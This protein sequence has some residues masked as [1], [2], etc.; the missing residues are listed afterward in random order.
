MGITYEM[1][2]DRVHPISEREELP[3]D[4]LDRVI[5]GF[6]RIADQYDSGTDGSFNASAM[7]ETDRI[8]AGIMSRYHRPIIYEASVGT[9]ARLE[10]IARLAGFSSPPIMIGSDL[11]PQMLEIASSRGIATRLLGLENHPEDIN[12]DASLILAGDIGY[13]LYPG[14]AKLDAEERRASV[15]EKYYTGLKQGGSLFLE[16]MHAGDSGRVW[17][18]QRIPMQDGVQVGDALDFYIKDFDLHEMV[19][20]FSLAGIPLRCA[21][22]Y[23]IERK[24]GETKALGPF[25]E[26]SRL[27]ELNRRS[28]YFALYVLNKT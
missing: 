12:P 3:S 28:S 22:L 2:E 15:L 18:Y 27:P 21:S 26:E 8:I 10:R 16:V 11:S 20:M 7:K 4:W 6:S 9:G 23:L 13:L 24:M 19:R 5:S 17:H 25:T 14:L 1:P